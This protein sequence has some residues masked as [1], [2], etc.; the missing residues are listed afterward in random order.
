MSDLRRRRH[1]HSVLL[2]GI[3]NPMSSLGDPR[4][5]SLQIVSQIGESCRNLVKI[6]Q[7]GLDTDP[8]FATLPRPGSQGECAPG[9]RRIR[10]KTK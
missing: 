9:G 6:P 7:I 3:D 2:P 1:G 10:S 5:P 8:N 4:L